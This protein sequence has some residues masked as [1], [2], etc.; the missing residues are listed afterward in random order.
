MEEWTILTARN[1]MTTLIKSEFEPIKLCYF[2]TVSEC[3]MRKYVARTMLAFLMQVRVFFGLTWP[4]PMVVLWQLSIEDSY[5]AHTR[6]LPYTNTH[7]P[8]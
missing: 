8:M 4:S 2:W 5:I 1:V 6:A 7:T 3:F